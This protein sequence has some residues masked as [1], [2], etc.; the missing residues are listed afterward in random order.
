MVLI[1]SLGQ[2][3]IAALAARKIGKA[4]CGRF[5]IFNSSPLQAAFETSFGLAF[6][7]YF[8]FALSSFQILSRQNL[9]ILFFAMIPFAL[10]EVYWDPERAALY[11]KWLGTFGIPLG[12]PGFFYTLFAPI[13]VF[14]R[15][16][17]G[18]M[19]L[20]D[21]VLGP[22]FLFTPFLLIRVKKTPLT[23][24]LSLFSLLFLFCWA[25]TTKQARFLIPVLPVLS[26]LI[27]GSLHQ[28]SSKLFYGVA[29]IFIFS[30][31]LVGAN[32]L[33]LSRSQ[34][35]IDL[36]RQALPHQYEKLWLLLE[37][38]LDRGFYLSGPLRHPKNQTIAVP[39]VQPPAALEPPTKIIPV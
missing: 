30:N 7:S 32:E 25:F 39:L 23:R 4:V 16:R 33:L 11:L 20:Y 6:I 2:I 22:L 13:L 26:F 36:S 31:F 28:I 17:F 35:Q 29:G 10:W 8:I 12:Q 9:W 19:H 14:V 5:F 18:E 15:A 1:F 37:Y 34:P 38:S 3:I 24:C 21:G 27:A